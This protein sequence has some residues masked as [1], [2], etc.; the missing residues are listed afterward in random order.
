MVSASGGRS[1]LSSADATILT[2][3]SSRRSE[4]DTLTDAVRSAPIQP[5][6]RQVGEGHVQDPLRDRRGE[7]VALGRVQ[8]L[9]GPETAAGRVVPAH[10]RLGRDERPVRRTDRLVLDGELVPL[11]RGVQVLGDEEPLAA[12][13]DGG[14]RVVGDRLAGGLGGVH[15][16]VRGEQHVAAVVRVV[17]RRGHADAGLRVQH[18]VAQLDRLDQALLE[19]AA[20]GHRRV[21]AARVGQDHRELVAAEPGEQ[22]RGLEGVQRAREAADHRLEELVA[23]RVAEGV[24]DLLEV[25]EVDQREREA[26]AWRGP[27]PPRRRTACPARRRAPAGSPP[28]SARR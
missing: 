13:A 18:D 1:C 10:Q 14:R 25:V 17:R 3:P 7:L 24:V 23:D 2:R 15:R 20:A 12:V 6:A 16:G 8:E 26:R 4:A 19:R 28:R 5:P 27:A 21:V 22:V 9:A 11:Q